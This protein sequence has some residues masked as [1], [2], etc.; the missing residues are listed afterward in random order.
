MLVTRNPP[1]GS[2]RK[3]SVMLELGAR[4]ENRNFG[5]RAFEM[6]K[7]KMS[8]CDFEHAQKTAARE[9]LL[10]DGRVTVMRLVAD[11]AGR[12]DRHRAKHL[13]VVGR[14]S[15]EVDDGEK[16]G[17]DVRLIARP[18]VQRRRFFVVSTMAVGF[19]IAIDVGGRRRPVDGWRRDGAR[20]V[21]AHRAQRD[22]EQRDAYETNPAMR[23]HEEPPAWKWR[24]D[25]YTA[26]S[27]IG[28]SNGHCG[29]WS[30]RDA[31]TSISRSTISS[32]V[33][34]TSCAASRTATCGAS[35]P[36]ATLETTGL[37][38]E[39]YLRLA[40]LAGHRRRRE[41]ALLRARLHDDAPRARRS[42]AKPCADKSAARRRSAF[43]SRTSS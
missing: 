42:R 41:D 38:N 7:K 26:D 15:I 36:D 33:T 20:S 13:A 32:L 6:S 12:R 18:D 8:F 24:R 22:T 19:V 21:A 4:V 40:S 35:D 3:S 1:S 37:V 23:A 14:P 9:D 34:T 43:R 31:A 16:V 30:R 25:G 5:Y 29:H 10:I 28:R 17:S 27:V 11:V 39:A 2:G